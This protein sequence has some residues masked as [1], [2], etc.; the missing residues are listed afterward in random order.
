M[1]E[2]YK[3][4]TILSKNEQLFKESKFEVSKGQIDKALREIHEAS[5]IFEKLMKVKNELIFNYKDIL[6]KK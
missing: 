5:H 6:S 4:R 3:E 2:I 1:K